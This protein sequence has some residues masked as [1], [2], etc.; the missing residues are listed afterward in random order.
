MPGAAGPAR[1]PRAAPAA[2]AGKKSSVSR[3]EG[4]RRPRPRTG[5]PGLCGAGRNLTFG[6]GW[7]RTREGPAVV[8]E[9]PE[10]RGD[11]TAFPAPG[12]DRLLPSPGTGERCGRGGHGSGEE[13]GAAPGSGRS[14]PSRAA[15]NG[16]ARSTARRG[17]A[18]PRSGGGRAA[19]CGAER[20]GSG[21][22]P[23]C[24]RRRCRCPRCCRERRIP[25]PPVPPPPPAA[26][27]GP[28]VPAMEP[29]AAGSAGTGYN[30]AL[31]HKVGPRARRAEG[32]P[33]RGGNAGAGDRFNFSGKL[34]SAS[35]PRSSFPREVR[36]PLRVAGGARSRRGVAVGR[37]CRLGS[38]LAKRN[39]REGWKG[40]SPAAQ[41][42]APS[43]CS[44]CCAL[45]GE[46][47]TP[48]L[49]A[50]AAVRRW[51]L[52]ATEQQSAGR[53]PLLSF[54]L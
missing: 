28:C 44:R 51:D 10:P 49:P 45:L 23:R 40:A 53:C 11:P 20:S 54:L 30:E 47:C 37:G 31:L 15:L 26:A 33:V 22:C 6:G 8:R 2:G 52:P 41:P 38:V 5:S 9:L 24:W 36:P 29:R 12:P 32:P 1:T 13:P 19:R 4:E 27:A 3:Y 14:E 42:A 17:C 34:R 16:T 7:R 48:G 50:G 21:R 25:D 39:E 43:G 18:G 35:P 46:S